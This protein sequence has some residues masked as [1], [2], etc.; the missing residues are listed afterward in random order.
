MKTLRVSLSKI[1]IAVSGI[2]FFVFILL[3]F[4]E[5]GA[6]HFAPVFFVPGAS[7]AARFSFIAI[8]LLFIFLHLFRNFKIPRIVL[9]SSLV[10]IL[11]SIFG[12]IVGFY[13]G[14]EVISILSHLS[15]SLGVIVCMV[16]G[17]LINTQNLEKS[18][19]LFS[20]ISLLILF[21]AISIVAIVFLN[22]S[23]VIRISLTIN[24]LA[25]PFVYGLIAHRKGAIFFLSVGIILLTGKRGI[26]LAALVTWL[27][28]GSVKK[29]LS[30]LLLAI[31]AF[32]LASPYL[33]ELDIWKSVLG[34]M[35]VEG[36]GLDE[37]SSGRGT[38]IRSLAVQLLV[39]NN[40]IFGL[41]YGAN[42]NA[43]LL[44][45]SV[46]EDWFTNGV[47]VIFGHYWFLFGFFFGTLLF[48]G[49]CFLVFLIYRAAI[50]EDLMMRLFGAIV[51]FSFVA[52]FSTFVV[53]DP[54]QWFM[55]GLA[56]SRRSFLKKRSREIN[57]N[58]FGT[59][60]D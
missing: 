55:M 23:T 39:G 54:F 59:L 7:L 56:L 35:E 51:F 43:T 26:W 16:S 57:F 15:G 46:V 19:F 9:N 36:L 45:E 32:I 60:G 37:I 33:V 24:A 48:L 50:C 44:F 34:R 1:Q 58:S 11:F 2:G 25:F 21:A 28:Y 20:A 5:T 52:S 41:G 14:H 3:S 42:F 53:W 49:H 29:M 8:C 13:N 10:V 47:D 4:L 38:V 40:A 18:G 17:S 6:R 27:L 12:V 31:L 30:S 22:S